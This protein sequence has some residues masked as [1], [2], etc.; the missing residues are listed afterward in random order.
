M[1]STQCNPISI[2]I[3]SPSLK[4][5]K[6]DVR[7]FMAQLNIAN[8]IRTYALT[9]TKREIERK[10]FDLLPGS[11]INDLTGSYTCREVRFMSS[12]RK[13]IPVITAS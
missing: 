13:I 9:E 10:R 7:T 12:V 1:E 2:T 5:G 3:T 6:P 4:K 8:G 11:I